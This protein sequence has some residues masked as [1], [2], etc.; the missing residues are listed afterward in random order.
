MP[1]NSESAV[2]KLLKS[3][4]LKLLLLCIFVIINMSLQHNKNLKKILDIS[5]IDFQTVGAEVCRSVAGV[6]CRHALA[7][8]RVPVYSS[9]SSEGIL[10]LSRVLT[11]V[12]ALGKRFSERI[13]KLFKWDFVVVPVAD[14]NMS[15]RDKKGF[16]LLKGYQLAVY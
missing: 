1:D 7:E 3:K 14:L 8:E 5:A 2:I 11:T 6:E 10:G 16:S 4:A 15:A 13:F 12:E 9:L